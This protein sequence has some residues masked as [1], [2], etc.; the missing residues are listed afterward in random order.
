MLEMTG[1]QEYGFAVELFRRWV[2]ENKPL[3]SIKD[4]LDQVDPLAEQLFSIGQEFLRR[5]QW[6]TAIRYFRDALE[7]NPRHFRAR[8]HLGETLLEAD[9][10]DSAVAELERA[11]KL[12]REETRPLLVRA[13]VVQARARQKAGDEQGTLEACERAL[14]I[15]PNEQAAQEIRN[16][17]R[18]R[19]LET[20]AKSH[21]QAEQWGEA[22]AAYDQLV[23]QATDERN[24]AVWKAALERCRKEGLLTHLFDE[25]IE[26][27]DRRNWQQAQRAFAEIVHT[28]PD[29]RVNGQLATQLLLQAVQRK[30]KRKYTPVIAVVFI[31]IL[32]V[33]IGARYFRPQED[34][35]M[36][37]P[38][39]LPENWKHVNTHRL[40]ANRDN[41]QEWVVLY[42]FDLSAGPAQDGSPIAGVVYQPDGSPSVLAAYELR[43]Q[44]GDY[45]CECECIASM[46]HVLSGL[47]GPE[48]I[49]RDHCNGEATRVSIFH[50]DAIREEYLPKGHFSGDRITLDSD[51]VTV[52]QRLPGRAQLA[53]EYI[54]RP[55]DEA[56]YY[57]PGGQGIAVM[58]DE[59]ETIFYQGMPEDVMLSPYP[60]KVVLAF[61]N[62]YTD[63]VETSEYFSPE[64]WAEVD[65]C[66]ANRC[67]CTSN[68]NEISRVRVIDLQLEEYDSE[69]AIVTVTVVC[70]HKNGQLDDQKT[71]EWRLAREGDRGKLKLVGVEQ[72]ENKETP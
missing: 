1:E 66:A 34:D 36:M 9:R 4:E 14:R 40:D 27:L 32:A 33:M 31:A 67:G 61:Y 13:L 43:P 22:I 58:H 71:L 18:L 26:A 38:V 48:L 15:S 46:E 64:T 10:T 69:Q 2:Y 11:Y 70:E 56:T 55:R 54:Y 37:P 42:R 7:T 28:R 62:D 44:D 50:W 39:E 63:A 25:G 57:Q 23:T 45:L 53:L 17:I 29:Y 47:E 52:A 8:L 3:Q 51:R 68:R 20:E 59:Y 49:V 5:H 72:N 65:G 41:N 12:D 24:R 21:E 6:E 60:E 35:Q 16:A 30:P 19:Q